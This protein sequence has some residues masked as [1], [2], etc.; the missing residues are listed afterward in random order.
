MAAVEASMAALVAE[1]SIQAS[2]SGGFR[3]G[4]RGFRMAVSSTEGSAAVSATGFFD[5][6]FDAYYAGYNYRCSYGYYGYPSCGYC[7]AY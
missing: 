7:L 1:A 6:D 2:A 4:D 5:G 3:L